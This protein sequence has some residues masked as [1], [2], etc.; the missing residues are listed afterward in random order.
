MI[1]IGKYKLATT[2]TD[3]TLEQGRRFLEWSKGETNPIELLAILMNTTQEIAGGVNAAVGEAM[4]ATIIENLEQDKDS[5]P[6]TAPKKL[7]GRKVS[8][9]AG[10]FTVAQAWMMDGLINQLKDKGMINLCDSIVACCLASTPIKDAE[11]EQIKADLKHEKFYEVIA[12]ANFFLSSY[13]SSLKRQ[14]RPSPQV[15]IHRARLR[16]GLK[17][18]RSS[19]SL[20][21]LFRSRQATSQSTMLL[22]LCLAIPHCFT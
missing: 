4:I 14:T 22:W 11:V 1:D 15:V 16:Q 21:R 5:V 13:N 6:D 9:D 10:K 8:F 3:L 12:A 18:L 2:W 7:L 19:V 20:T 17:S